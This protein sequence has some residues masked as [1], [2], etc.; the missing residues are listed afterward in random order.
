MGP[1]WLVVHTGRPPLYKEPVRRNFGGFFFF[2]FILTLRCHKRSSSLVTVVGC[3][4]CT[5]LQSAIANFP[6]TGWVCHSRWGSASVDGLARFGLGEVWI[7]QFLIYPL[8]PRI[9]SVRETIWLPKS[10]DLDG[11]KFQVGNSS[12]WIICVTQRFSILRKHQPPV[13]C[14]RSRRNW[15]GL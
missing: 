9:Y 8:R 15:S 13:T 7:F 3:L 6:I 11:L 2:L 5:A 4:H 1:S 14:R 12:V 10:G